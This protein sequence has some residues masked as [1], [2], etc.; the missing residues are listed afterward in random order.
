M[1]QGQFAQA[2]EALR[3]CLDLLEPNHPQRPG[4]TGLLGQCQRMIQLDEKLQAILQGTMKPADAAEC[5][6]LAQLC[7]QH[8]QLYVASACF[9]TE[10]FAKQPKLAD[11][12]QRQ[13]RYNAACAAALAGCGAGKD[14]GQLGEPVRRSW[15]QQAL[16]WLRADLAVWGRVLDNANARTRTSVQKVLRHWQTDPD[17]AGVREPA[18]LARLPAEERQAWQKLWTDVAALLKRSERSEKP[19]TKE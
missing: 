18:E 5:L 11:D 19:P 6:A 13:H 2:R 4:V 10:A 16:D 12:L 3:R 1:L 15:R 14:A 17:L 8:K 9:S 7:Q